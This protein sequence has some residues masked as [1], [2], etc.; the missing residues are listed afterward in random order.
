MDRR[1]I[2][3]RTLINFF[4]KEGTLDGSAADLGELIALIKHEEKLYGENSQSVLK[5]KKLRSLQETAAI[6][7]LNTPENQ[8]SPRKLPA[9]KI[10]K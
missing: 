10:V 2:T 7:I 6:R 4:G 3:I 1:K 5:L 8:L 9:L